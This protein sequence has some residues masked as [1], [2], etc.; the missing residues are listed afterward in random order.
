MLGEHVSLHQPLSACVDL[1]YY[2]VRR[3]CRDSAAVLA[4]RS[5]SP[6][7]QCNSSLF[8]RRDAEIHGQATAALDLTD[9]DGEEDDD[10]DAVHGKR[11]HATANSCLMSSR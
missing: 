10:G 7:R 1:Y 9:G 11:S 4:P 2:H 3:P 6:P 5:R 8:T